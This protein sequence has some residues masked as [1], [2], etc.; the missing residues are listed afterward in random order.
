[1][2]IYYGIITNSIDVTDIC[3]KK[4]TKNNIITIPIGDGNR[5]K[6]FTDPLPGVH[7]K[8]L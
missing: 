4:L 7:K 1:M 6:Y 3:L 2:K 8:I 5:S